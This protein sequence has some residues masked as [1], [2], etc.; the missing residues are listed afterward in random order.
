MVVNLQQAYNKALDD[1][2]MLEFELE[3]CEDIHKYLSLSAQIVKKL[4]HQ[5]L[6]KIMLPVEMQLGEADFS[7]FRNILKEWS[8]KV[9]Y[10]VNAFQN[11]DRIDC[12]ESTID[13]LHK[14]LPYL[15]GKIKNIAY[16][17]KSRQIQIA[18]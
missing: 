3:G 5:E 13:I 10:M 7:D 18:A 16:Y 9:D 1:A 12:D 6:I 15:N 17:K 2:D 11:G 14:I 4:Y 8:S